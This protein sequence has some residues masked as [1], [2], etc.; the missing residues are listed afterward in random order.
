M[1]LHVHPR[2]FKKG[3]IFIEY[4]LEFLMIFIA[5]S[6]SFLA[7]NVRENYVEKH[8]E[9]KLLKNMLVDLKN[10]TSSLRWT[11]EC[12]NDQLKGL[13]S[14]LDVLEDTINIDN[15]RK[16]SYYNN[17]YIGTVN[18]FMPNDRT[19]SNLKNSGGFRLINDS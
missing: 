17:N 11:I 16:A 18:L 2:K 13:D 12:S 9:K 8:R 5:V 14:L 6:G 15:Q 7:E 4:L 19:I 1:G 3:K 10:D